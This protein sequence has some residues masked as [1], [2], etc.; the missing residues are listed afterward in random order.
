VK[1]TSSRDFLPEEAARPRRR[2]WLLAN[3]TSTCLVIRSFVV[4]IH[5]LGSFVL[6]LGVIAIMVGL[7]DDYK[8]R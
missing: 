5:Q 3:P 1:A 2:E 7:G 8:T 4:T 6:G